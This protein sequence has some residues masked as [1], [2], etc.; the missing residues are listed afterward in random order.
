MTDTEKLN[1][2]LKLHEISVPVNACKHIA[3]R[4]FESYMLKR[5]CV[6]Y[7]PVAYCVG[8]SL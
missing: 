3:Y 8:V 5:H 4:V 2:L 7:K 6:D 1:A